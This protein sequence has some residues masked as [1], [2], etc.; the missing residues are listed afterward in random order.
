MDFKELAYKRHSVRKYS[1]RQ[2]SEEDIND[3]LKTACLSPSACNSQPWKFI[4][5]RDET[6]ACI[7]SYVT[8]KVLPI[9]RWAKE[10]STFVVICETKARLMKNI[11]VGSQHFAQMDIG[12][13]TATLLYAAEDKGISSCV[14]G[15]FNEKKVRKLL[16]IPKNVKIRLI[17]ALGYSDEDSIRE[18]SRKSFDD[19]VS[20]NKW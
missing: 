13:A 8:S 12:I 2:I 18:K 16:G 20:Y 4:V 7:S 14:M 5:A 1:D 3:I 19:I 9:N 6:A 17:V 15:A 10:V 11:P